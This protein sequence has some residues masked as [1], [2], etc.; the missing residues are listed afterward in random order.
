MR[1]WYAE[2]SDGR[3]FHF[4]TSDGDNPLETV[5]D[6][7]RGEDWCFDGGGV[8]ESPLIRTDPTDDSYVLVKK[9]EVRRVFWN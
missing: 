2:L 7:D 9:S 8:P 5:P 1:R 6:F 3:V 4:Y